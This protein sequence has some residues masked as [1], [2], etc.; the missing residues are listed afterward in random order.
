MAIAL[1]FANPYMV[2]PILMGIGYVAWQL[3]DIM[4]PLTQTIRKDS[5]VRGPMHQL[6][7]TV[8]N[9]LVTIRAYGKENYFE[10]A[11]LIENEKSANVTYTYFLVS[12]VLGV[13][14]DLMLMFVISATAVMAL[15]FKGVIEAGVLAFSLANIIDTGV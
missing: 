1:C 8:I 11:Y 2:I 5:V 4:P 14:L 6:F 15:A 13:R 7:S 3:G 10:T 9:G 12:R